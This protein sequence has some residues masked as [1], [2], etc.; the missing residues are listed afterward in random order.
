M[1]FKRT[2]MEF[3]H[4]LP[5][6][7]QLV[8]KTYLGGKHGD[9]LDPWP[10]KNWANDWA[11]A[12]IPGLRSSILEVSD[13]GG[14]SYFGR[15]PGA[16]VDPAYLFTD[17]NFGFLRFV[18]TGIAKPELIPIVVQV[19]TTDAPVVAALLAIDGTT[20]FNLRIKQAEAIAAVKPLHEGTQFEDPRA[21]A[22]FFPRFAPV[23]PEVGYIRWAVDAAAGGRPALA[24]VTMMFGPC[25]YQWYGCAE[26]QRPEES[27][28]DTAQRMSKAAAD[29]GPEAAYV[30][31][32]LATSTDTTR[33]YEYWDMHLQLYMDG[34]KLLNSQVH[35][36]PP[37]RYRP[38]FDHLITSSHLISSHRR[39]LMTLG[40]PHIPSSCAG[41]AAGRRWTGG[42]CAWWA[43]GPAMTAGRSRP[44]TWPCRHTIVTARAGWNGSTR[45]RTARPSWTTPHLAVVYPSTKSPSAR[46]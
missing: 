40:V 6:P 13:C 20:W 41:P 44:A 25:P 3:V 10:G 31:A 29:K 8:V 22:G 17:N 11:E 12:A 2:W 32:L 27:P 26:R 18:K 28:F 23:A 14:V 37:R 38:A 45:S 21:T 7:A 15:G 30:R 36:P 1:R 39:G 33:F 24:H 43:P 35:L 42:M 46:H 19:Q 34:A 4:Q 9:K 5:P 16:M